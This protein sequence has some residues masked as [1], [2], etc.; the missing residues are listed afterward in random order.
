MT[1]LTRRGFVA[2]TAVILF[3]A[4]LA[5][6]PLN[7]GGDGVAIKGYDPVAY[8]N[9][10]KPVAGSPD[11]TAVHG[12]AT[13]RFASAAN[14]AAF[15]ADPDKYVP[16]YGGFCAYAMA[17]GYQAPI[18]PQAF[19]VV[20]DKL[21]LNYSKS[22]RRTWQGDQAGYIAKADRNWKDLGG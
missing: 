7:V 10:S 11:H 22:V 4:P 17:K 6:A 13:Y 3:T 18:D 16:A 20:N 14:L 1:P 8:F 21:Y 15:K 12:G 9:Q 19:S 5:A 2:A